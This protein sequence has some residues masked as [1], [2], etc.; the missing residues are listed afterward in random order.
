MRDVRR[1]AQS[2]ALQPLL[3]ERSLLGAV[4]DFTTNTCGVSSLVVMLSY[5]EL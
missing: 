3:G 1:D 4:T 2:P 5:N